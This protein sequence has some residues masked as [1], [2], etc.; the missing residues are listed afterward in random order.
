MNTIVKEKEN[1]ISESPY[2]VIAEGQCLKLKEI[3]KDYL[4]YQIG[5]HPTTQDFALCIT[6]NDNAGLH[7]KEWITLNAIHT[8]LSEYSGDFRSSIFIPLFHSK[9]RNNAGFLVAV[10]KSE[11]IGLLQKAVGYHFQYCKVSDYEA[12]LA[13]LFRQWEALVKGKA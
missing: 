9:S 7:S 4:H 5:Y 13:I 11:G 12:R 2:Q 10:L 6:G 3:P 1:A 8:L